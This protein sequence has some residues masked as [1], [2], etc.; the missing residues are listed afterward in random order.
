MDIIFTVSPM[1]FRLNFNVLNIM[2]STCIKT[3][4]SNLCDPTGSL[5]NG[6]CRCVVPECAVYS[7]K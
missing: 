2:R 6:A 5:P 7:T 3:R 4:E 1:N